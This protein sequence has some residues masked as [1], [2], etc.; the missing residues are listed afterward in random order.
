MDLAPPKATVIRGGQPVEI[1]TSGVVQDV[2]VLIRPV[3]KVPVNGEVI[4]GESSVDESMITGE[5]LPVKKKVGSNVIGATINKNNTFKFC[6]TKVGT[7]TALAQIVKL[8]Q[9]AQNSK[10]PSQR[11]ADRAAQWR[12]M[13]AV[14]FSLATF[15]GWYFLGSAAIPAGTSTS[16]WELMMA[17]TVLVITCP[18]ALGLAAPTAVMVGTGLRPR[19][20]SFIKMLRL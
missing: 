13:A 19:T 8:V 15:F 3:D 7:D 12:V 17:I 2:I 6:A 20:A 16:A 14:L 10:A 9:I 18:D 4:E 5:S 11:L 1:S